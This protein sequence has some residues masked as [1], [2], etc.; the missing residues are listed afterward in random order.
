MV[1]TACAVPTPRN[2][3][4]VVAALIAAPTAPVTNSLRVAVV[5]MMCSL[6]GS[7]PRMGRAH[8]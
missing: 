1:T 8:R 5:V 4:A 2:S 3:S 7:R 6:C